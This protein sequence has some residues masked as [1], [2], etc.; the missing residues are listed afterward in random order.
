[1][2]PN[3]SESEGIISLFESV[4]WRL[5]VNNGL[6]GNDVL[7]FFNEANVDCLMIGVSFLPRSRVEDLVEWLKRDGGE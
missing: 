3:N 1:M 5:V 7:M 2:K 4:G 6:D